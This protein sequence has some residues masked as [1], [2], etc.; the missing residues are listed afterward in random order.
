MQR[1]KNL[2]YQKSDHGGWRKPDIIAM[3]QLIQEL[4][5][6]LVTENTAANVRCLR[7]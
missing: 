5:G 2:K 1:T 7:R 3:L 6:V 4:L